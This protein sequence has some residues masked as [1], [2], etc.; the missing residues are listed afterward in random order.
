MLQQFTEGEAVQAK[1]IKEIQSKGVT[2]HYWPKEILDAY[3]K[4][5]GEVIEEQ[6]AKS[7]EF[8]KV[9]ASLSKFREE[10]KVWRQYGYLK[11]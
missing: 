6:K 11:D 4:A 9:W 3:R 8:A 7:P 5:W 10:Y 1:A 2:V